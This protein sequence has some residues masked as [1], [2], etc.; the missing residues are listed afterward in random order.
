M[1]D[2]HPDQEFHFK[3]GKTAKNIWDL[4]KRM[5]L[6]GDDE[7][8][9]HVG[10]NKNDFAEW[11]QHAVNDSQLAEKLRKSTNKDMA[12]EVLK[13]R[14]QQLS[15]ELGKSHVVSDF[16]LIKDFL[17]GLIIG[18]IVGAALGYFVLAP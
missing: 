14:I 9:S 15:V 18:L 11:V 10:P 7:Y 13:T 16:E 17:I 4:R 3:D 2:V 5:E 12:I 1:E 6:M 8:G